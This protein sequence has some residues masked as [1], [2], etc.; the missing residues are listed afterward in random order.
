MVISWDLE[1]AFSLNGWLRKGQDG[2][3]SKYSW[4]QGL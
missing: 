1:G 2:D 3:Q 4:M